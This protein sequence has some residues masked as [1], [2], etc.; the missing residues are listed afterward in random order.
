LYTF[1]RDLV[2]CL[3]LLYS[4]EE[5]QAACHPWSNPS[6]TS[7]LSIG[8]FIIFTL[9]YFLLLI[10]LLWRNPKEQR[11]AIAFLRNTGHRVLPT[12]P[13]TEPYSSTLQSMCAARPAFPKLFEK[14]RV[15]RCTD[16]SIRRGSC[17]GFSLS[18]ICRFM[19]VKYVN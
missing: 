18:E 5:F 4:L 10:Y 7:L 3:V 15:K 11:A 17:D 1:I 19:T 2:L 12:K 6:L 16:S 14:Q 9:R 13:N 8:C